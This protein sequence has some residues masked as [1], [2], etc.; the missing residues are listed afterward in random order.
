[1]V[2]YNQI[3][4]TFFM[5]WYFSESLSLAFNS[6]THFQEWDLKLCGEKNGISLLLQKQN[7]VV[8]QS[9]FANSGIIKV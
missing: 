5:G 4:A 1:M 9:L 8:I 3:K 6:L 7:K 2:H